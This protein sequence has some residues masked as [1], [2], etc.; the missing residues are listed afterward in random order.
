MRGN[1]GKPSTPDPLSPL[2]R[3]RRARQTF[4]GQD[5]YVTGSPAWKSRSPSMLCNAAFEDP[6]IHQHVRAKVEH[7]TPIPA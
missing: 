2:K 7:D 1:L 6:S 5:E 4:T 3:V